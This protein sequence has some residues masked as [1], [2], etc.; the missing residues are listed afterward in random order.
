MMT[1]FSVIRVVNITKTDKFSPLILMISPFSAQLGS[2]T[3]LL[4]L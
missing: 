4:P 3:H 2:T 1:S